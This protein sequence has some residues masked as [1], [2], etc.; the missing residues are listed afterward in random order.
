MES[1]ND[2][3]RAGR[4]PQLGALKDVAGQDESVARVTLSDLWF[5]LWKRR[6][7]VIVVVVLV[8]GADVSYTFLRKPVYESVVQLQYD[9]SKSGSLGVEEAITQTLSSGDADVHL[10]TQVMILQSETVFMAVIKNLDLVHNPAFVPKKDFLREVKTSDP[11][12]MTPKQREYL[13]LRFR[14]AVK[15]SVLPRTQVIEVRFRSEDPQLAAAVANELL[16]AYSEQNFRARFQ[17]AMQVSQWLSKQ[18]DDLKGNAVDAQR[19]LAAFEKSNNILGT[20]EKDNIATDRL[21]QLNLQCVDAEVDRILKEARYR[22]AQSGNPELL[23]AVV[24]STSLQVLRTQEAELNSQLAQLEA[25]YGSGYPK[26]QELRVQLA[27]QRAAIKDEVRNVGERLRDEYMAATR[28][29]NMLRGQLNEQKQEVYKLNDG[30]ASLATLKHEVDSSQALSDM[31]EL[32]LKEAGVTA[33]LSS[34]NI[35]VIERGTVPHTPIVPRTALNLALGI[36]LGLFFGAAMA[37]LRE[38]FDDAAH[39]S[40][41]IEQWTSLPALASLPYVEDQGFAGGKPDGAGGGISVMLDAPQSVL[42]EAYRGLRTSILFSMVDSQPRTILFTSS[43][44][45]EGKTTSSVNCAIALAQKGAKVLLVDGDIRR[46][47]VHRRFGIDS[48]R[49]LSGLLAARNA[50]DEADCLRSP[51]ASL[52]NLQVL[53]SGPRPPNPGE[54]LASRRMM[55]KLNEWREEYDHVVIDS[56]PIMLVSDPLV[57]S[58]QVDAVVLVSRAGLTRKK[59]L[60]RSVE[61]LRRAHASVLG[62]VLNAANM[63]L[64]HYYSGPYRYYRHYNYTQGYYA[65]DEKHDSERQDG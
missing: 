65:S 62:V 12:K 42:A 49:G 26:V 56:P 14:K 37:F 17:G 54:M 5:T 41:Q 25:K 24:P 27:K 53:T 50:K 3:L 45:S 31:L 61:L 44:P 10:Q 59:A 11:E 40:D 20:D 13:L 9:S 60:Q 23:A 7:L 4:L 46:P 47:S 1:K 6:I 52:P 8:F 34:A 36:P 39:T 29:E 48:D 2:R 55:D 32:K 22:M 18:M 51:L 38:S 64:E 35:S 28:S 58:T 63:S 33:G 21:K 15:V 16:E 43:Y 57:L 30:A 19:R